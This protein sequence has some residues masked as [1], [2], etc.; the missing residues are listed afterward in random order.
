MDDMYDMDDMDD[1]YGINDRDDVE[2]VGLIRMG[3]SDRQ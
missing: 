2:W 3:R 1:M